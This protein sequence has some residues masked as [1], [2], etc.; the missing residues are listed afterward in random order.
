MNWEAIGA[1][2][3]ILGALAVVATLGYLAAQTRQANHLA[4]TSAVLQLQNEMREHRN[5]LA[6]SSELSQIMLKVSNDEELTDLEAMRLIARNDAALTMFESIYLQFEAGIIT[7][8]DFIRHTPVMRQI[9]LANRKQGIRYESHSV[10]F[11]EFLDALS[12]DSSA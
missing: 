4:R 2:G 11:R 1:V 5:S 10:G 3:E 8:E 9:A 12:E 7:H 6:L